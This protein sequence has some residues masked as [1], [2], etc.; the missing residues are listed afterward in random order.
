MLSFTVR[1]PL[2]VYHALSLSSNE[3]AE[4][5]PNPL[6]L[7]GALLAAAHARHGVDPDADRALLQRLCEAPPPLILAPESV[8]VDEQDGGDAVA[9]LRGATRWAPR[10]YVTRG[11]VSP[12]NLG[13]DRA[14]V[15]KA[16]VAVGDRAVAF[17]WPDLELDA[18]DLGRLGR[19]AGDVTFLG[20]TRSP[21]IVEVDGGAVDAPRERAWMPV[22]SAEQ[23]HGAVAVRIADRTSLSAFDHRHAARRSTTAR[24]Q[25]G[26]MVPAI[27][28]GRTVRY[29]YAPRLRE[30]ERA[31]DPR[32]WGEM[33]VLAIDRE[34]EL[35]PKA[36]AAYV[37]GR[38]VRVA[39]LGA[40]GDV[41]TDGE[42]PPIL[43]GRGAEPHCAI[44][45]LPNVWGSH[46]DSRILG[47][48]LVLP[49][50]RRVVDLAEQRTRVEHG[51]RRLVGSEDGQERRF[52]RI[53]GAG[54][55]WLTTPDPRRARLMTLRQ[56]PYRRPSHTW[57]SVTPVVHSHWRK[58]GDGAL[59]RQIAADC[60]HVGLPEPAEV[61]VLRGGDRMIPPKRVPKEWRGLL[62]GPAERVRIT[63]A[64][65]VHGPVLL[66]R[67][68]HFG[69]GLC[70]PE[71]ER[72]LEHG[73]PAARTA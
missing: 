31:L 54:R 10:N 69:L 43:C 33:I 40:Y 7:I 5:P 14:E 26:G 68:R 57:V 72:G 24:V 19:L 36:A 6:R 16:G 39:L 27:P 48:G 32:W 37:L 34:S 45:A 12:R 64:Q 56:R 51:L 41:G 42:A 67:A 23:A 20:T 3:D 58:A 4:W 52:V 71:P 22:R 66:G 35:T 17:T 61:E 25:P 11:A 29:A 49:H 9:R 70:V 1:F 46:P 63:F 65:P 18:S 30:E 55:I 15:S 28:I 62:S 50:E 13:R 59:L 8:A 47:I 2:G 44:V 38:A 73:P 53:P 60:A 21:A